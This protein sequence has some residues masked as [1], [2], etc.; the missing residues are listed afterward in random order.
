MLLADTSYIDPSIPGLN[1]ATQGNDILIN[2]GEGHFIS[3]FKNGFCS[4]STNNNP[5]DVT[6][7]IPWMNGR[8]LGYVNIPASG[9]T[10]KYVYT[11][12]MLKT[13]LSTGPNFSDPAPCGAAG[14][15]E[16][17]YLYHYP[18]ARKAV[19]SGKYPSGLAY[20][21]AV[22]KKRGDKINAK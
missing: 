18:D 19:E 14:F 7:F 12:A 2:E 22:G 15:H 4:F 5:P 20:Y 8:K 1:C 17:Y 16:W 3:V 21:L 6:S 11:W 9:H 10:P 13:P